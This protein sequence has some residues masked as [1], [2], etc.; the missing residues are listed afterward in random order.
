MSWYNFIFSEK[1][2]YR[3]LVFWLLWWIYFTTSYYHYQQSGLQKVEFEPWNFPFFIRSILLLSIHITACYYFINYLMPQYLFKA[4]YMAFVM[5]ILVLGFLILL[6]SYFIHKTVMPFINTVFNYKP[7]IANQNIWWT[8]ITSG[9][10]SAPKVISAAAAIKLLKRWWLKQKEKERLEKEK[11]ITDLQ[12]LKAQMHPEFLFSSLD[13]ICLMT[14]KKNT[15]GASMLLLKL[16]DIL[17]Y[18]LY[19]C[20]NKLVLL[21]K[22]IKVIRDYLVLEKTRM[23]NRLEIDVA[24][25]GEAGT[26]MIA[27]LLL[28]SLIENSFLY[29]GNKNPETNWI[30]LELQIETNE[31]SMKLI[32]GKATEPLGLPANENCIVKAMKRLDFFYP[33]NYEL[34]TTIEPEIM[35]TYLRIVLEESVNENQNSIYTSEQMIYA[36]V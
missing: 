3:H 10:L 30:N 28:F 15:A 32:H 21:E 11:L 35:I 9:L 23:G 4:R 19:E 26:K 12:L 2:S 34:K 31:I 5:H 6:S 27:P 24:V 7:A 29:F 14:Q 20:D 36:T 33:G 18:I 22:E 8:S 13:S 17:S 25:K 1:K 16:A